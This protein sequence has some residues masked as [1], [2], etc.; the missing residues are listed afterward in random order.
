M[1]RGLWSRKAI[2]V[3]HDP[4]RMTPRDHA[5]ACTSAAQSLLAHR[6]STDIFKLAINEPALVEM[7]IRRR[8]GD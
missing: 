1:A 2:A 7:F 3:D 8:H 6:P 4:L 5:Q